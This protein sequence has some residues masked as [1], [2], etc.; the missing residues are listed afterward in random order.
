V[1]IDF[2]DKNTSLNSLWIVLCLIV[3]VFINFLGAG[4]YGEAEFVFASIK[5]LTIVG[6]IILGIILDLGGGPDH[7][8]LGF[9]YWKHPGPFVQYHGISG[10]EGRFL[11]WWAVMTQAAFSFI[12][13]EIVAIAA[14]EAKNPRRN[15]PKAIRRVYI[16]ILLFYI[17]GVTII[18]LLV[19]SNDPN[20]GLT[21]SKGTAAASPF[22]IAIRRSG[23]KALPSIINACLLTSAWSAASSD[24]YTS[25]RALY[26]LAV[27]RN[28]P[29]IFRRTN[30]K[31]L[32]WVALLTS[33]AFAFL[34][35]MGV[36]AGSGKVFG[37][38]A[39][40]TSV[41][42]LMTWFGIAVTYIRFYA[43]MKAQGLDRSKLPYHSKLQPYAA[44]YAA[45]SCL[46]I[47]FFSGWA[48]FLKDNWNT[49]TFVTNYIPLILFPILYVGAKWWKRSPIILASE[50]DFQSGIAEIEAETY[51]EP[52]PRN[53]WEAFWQWLM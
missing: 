51:D 19:P 16:R 34:A 36:S 28:A 46:L 17:G 49:A 31:G 5:V 1:L 12:G 48:V 3:V 25:S 29:A 22:V 4:A 42:G 11:G 8:R 2:W 40:M 15:L 43:G 53:K 13:T 44:W 35:F 24:M 30:R 52:P 37:W 41:A 18:G 9:R 14:G 10:A 32:P 39:N 38:F 45:I 33:T 6:L 27:A 21:Q 7:D 47:C 50:M 26:G 20:L 23:I